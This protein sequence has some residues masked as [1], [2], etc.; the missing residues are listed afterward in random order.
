MIAPVNSVAVIG[1]T[2]LQLTYLVQ[3][4]VYFTGLLSWQRMPVTIDDSGRVINSGNTQ[5]SSLL[6]FECQRQ[7]LG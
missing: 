4:L 5:V 6:F 3:I 1:G 2:A 7:N